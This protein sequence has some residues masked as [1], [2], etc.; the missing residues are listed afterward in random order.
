MRGF[1]NDE[2]H[3]DIILAILFENFY[4]ILESLMSFSFNVSKFPQKQCPFTLTQGKIGAY[5]ST[6]MKK[7]TNMRF[8]FFFFWRGGGNTRTVQKNAPVVPKQRKQKVYNGSDIIVTKL[9]LRFFG[10]IILVHCSFFWFKKKPMRAQI[11][12]RKI[13]QK[14]PIKYL[15]I[16]YRK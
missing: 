7:N 13:K 1:I 4:Q 3:G 16:L 8:F 9:C 11:I 15:L 5:F 10:E 12:R 14:T 2:K 6:V